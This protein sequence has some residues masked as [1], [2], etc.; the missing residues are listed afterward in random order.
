MV[1]TPAC[2][3]GR[4]ACQVHQQ[5]QT[6][7]LSTLR[8]TGNHFNLPIPEPELGVP[9]KSPQMPSPSDLWPAF[10]RPEQEGVLFEMFLIRIPRAQERGSGE[11]SFPFS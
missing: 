1:S 5:S 4:R 3:R 8:K 9:F 7:V 11:N 6:S 2:S 10:L